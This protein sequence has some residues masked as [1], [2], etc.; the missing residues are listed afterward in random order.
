VWVGDSLPEGAVPTG[1]YEGWNW[2]DSDPTPISD[3]YAHQSALIPNDVHQHYFTGATETLTVNAGDT[4]FAYV[5]L[6]PANPPS[7][8]MLQWNDGTWEHRAYWGANQL[9]W[10]TNGTNSRRYMGPLPA[11]DQWVRLE[12]PASAVGLEGRTLNG[13]AF[14]L[15]GGMATWDDAG[16]TGQGVQSANLASGKPTTQSSVLNGSSSQLAVDGNTNGNYYAGSVTH[17]GF[18]AQAWWQVD[19][20]AKNWLDQVR[21]WN[22]TDCCAERLSDFYVFVSDEPFA[23]TDANETQEQPGVSTYFVAGQAG[24]P[25]VIDVGRSGRYVRVQLSGANY[26]SLAEVEVFGKPASTTTAQTPALAIGDASVTEGN[27]GSASASF[28]VSLSAASASTVVVNY[29]TGDG[30]AVAYNDYT[31]VSGALTFSPGQTT[32]TVSVPVVGDTAVEGNETFSVN[33]SNP[34]NATV[35]DGQG[36]GT[37]LNDDSATTPPPSDMVWVEDSLPAG[38]TPGQDND[39]WNWIGSNPSPVSGGLA[40]QSN[41]YGGLHQHYF[42]WATNT[43]AANAGDTLIAYVYLDPAN[44]P[45]EVML[46]WCS[47]QEGWNHRAYWGA[48][49]LPWGTDGTGSRRFMGA[50]PAAGQWVR[51][52]VPAAQVGLE[53]KTLHGMAFSLYGGRAAWDRAGKSPANAGLVGYWKFDEGVGMTAA[54]S[55]GGAHHG[56]LQ[57]GALW[58]Q[59]KLGSALSFDG[60]DDM[61]AT[62]GIT[63]VTNNFTLAFWALPTAPHE[64]DPES[65]GNIG[66]TSGQRYAFWPAWYDSGH[67]GAG[68]SVGTNGVSVYEHAGGYMPSPLVYQAALNNWTHVAVVYENRQPRLYVNGV[69]V[70]T[71]LTS[72]KG[73]V[74]LNPSYIGGQSYGYYAGRLDDVRAYSRALTPGEVSAL[75][76]TVPPPS[77]SASVSWVQPAEVSWGTPNTLTAAGYAQ[78]GS[79]GVQLVWRDETAGTGWNTVAYQATPGSDGAWSNTIPASNKC[80]TY[81]VYVNYSGVR[82]PDYVY[83]GL[84]SG[85]CSETASLIWIQPQSSAGFGPP[86]SLVVAGSAKNG[87][88]GTQV[89]LSYR[90]VTAGSAWSQLGYG[91]TPDANDIWYNSIEGANPYHVYQ[92]RVTYDAVTSSVCT[93]QGTN[94]ISWC[95]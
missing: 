40:H 19:L 2:V 72:L 20:G 56:A 54:D 80:H 28:A 73:F 38:A 58:A 51:L 46:Q 15:Y 59:G 9:P 65:N 8:V 57:N 23:S 75:F 85:Y 68:V 26:L 77:A 93:Y 78:N 71:G 74:H 55:S 62:N 48:N 4:L 10:G 36:L 3:S 64:I 79:G 66:G 35:T 42:L 61:V 29:S 83:N 16:K 76:N 33:L 13:M 22:R 5:Y 32:K 60:A 49:Q 1:Y 81:R 82:S 30:T 27:G 84:S 69:L 39:N 67:A 12:V 11:T 53:G 95:Q 34:S 92:V 89:F 91:P 18:E 45:S 17:T 24:S 50:L 7:E 43:L 94:S 52:E 87:P 90:D 86:G 14:T 44:P 63:D 47:N 6:D 21:V 88:S 31:P 25:S 37:I 41:V 70:R